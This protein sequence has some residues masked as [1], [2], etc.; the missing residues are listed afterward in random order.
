MPTP[1]TV[2]TQVDTPTMVAATKPSVETQGEATTSL[3]VATLPPAQQEEEPPTDPADAE[4]LQ[5]ADGF[6]LVKKKKGWK[7]NKKEKGKQKGLSPI[8]RLSLGSSEKGLDGRYWQSTSPDQPRK[9]S[10]GGK[11]DFCKA[12]RK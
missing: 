8:Q 10:P 12:G 1:I 11:Q 5:L 9:R 2:E 4:A 3:P 7:N 6:T